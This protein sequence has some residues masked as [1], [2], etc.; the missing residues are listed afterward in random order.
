MAGDFDTRLPAAPELS[1]QVCGECGAVNYPPRELCGDCLADALH[2]RAV[3]DTGVVQSLTEL[4]YSL[5]PHYASRLPWR[6]ASVRLDCGP[7][8]FTHLQ[9]GV[10][11]D[12]P[13]AVRP[14]QDAAGHRMLVA[15]ARGGSVESWNVSDWAALGFREIEA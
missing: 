15:T 4:H 14:L 10:A 8:V 5:E 13:V 12:D 6:V 11:I 3:A 1:L 7:V 2:W 9:P